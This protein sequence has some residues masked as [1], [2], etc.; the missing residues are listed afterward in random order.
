[1]MIWNAT[2]KREGFIFKT[3]VSKHENFQ[4]QK[5]ATDYIKKII[6]VLGY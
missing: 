3:G 1:M 4:Q 5:I 2:R 6:Q